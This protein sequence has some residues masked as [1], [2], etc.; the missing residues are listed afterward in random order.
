VVANLPYHVATP[1]ITNLLVHPELCPA[2]FVVT[3]QREVADR[4]CARPAS[5]AYGAVSVVVQALSEVSLVRALPPNVFWP[6]PKVDSAVMA[7]RPI[8]EKRAAVADVAGFQVLVRRIFLHRRKY[9]R[10]VLAAIW[11]EQW[12]KADVDRWLASLGF[13]GQLRAE[14][15][16]VEEFVALAHA[17]RERFGALPQALPGA[18]ERQHEE[19]DSEDDCPE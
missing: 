18:L 6:K 19:G 8:A 11:D 15:L 5:H 7:I 17:L 14:A 3:I 13:S 1:V 2:L 9:L 4:L 10:H 16:A 12:T